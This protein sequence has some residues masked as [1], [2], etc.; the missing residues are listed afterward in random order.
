MLIVLYIGFPLTGRTHQIRVHLQ[1]LGHP[2]LNDPLY[3]NQ[4]WGP[5][6]GKECD[7]GTLTKDEILKAVGETFSMKQWVEDGDSTALPFI[8]PE[9][10]SETLPTDVKSPYYDETCGYC[11]FVFRDPTR[12]E[13]TLFL[14]AL[15]YE[16]PG[17]GYETPL[18]KWAL[19][20]F[21]PAFEDDVTKRG[22]DL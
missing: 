10:A 9:K 21:V 22:K 7:Y 16:G 18:P 4:G 3:H 1:Y 11:Q 5:N 17:F 13:L 19:K 20:E 12:H 15:R 6:L 2:I 14:H 8:P